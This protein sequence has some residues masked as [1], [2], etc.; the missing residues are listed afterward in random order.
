MGQ[1]QY[2]W[3][4]S[5]PWQVKGRSESDIHSVQSHE[6]RNTVEESGSIVYTSKRRLAAVQSNQLNPDSTFAQGEYYYRKH[7]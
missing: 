5:D 3:S 2:Y 4:E 1:I 7:R 6:T